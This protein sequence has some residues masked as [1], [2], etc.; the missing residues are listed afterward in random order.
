M[1]ILLE[2]AYEYAVTDSQDNSFYLIAAQTSRSYC[3]LAH[4]IFTS[5]NWCHS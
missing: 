1:P 2:S 5:N 3:D 4:L